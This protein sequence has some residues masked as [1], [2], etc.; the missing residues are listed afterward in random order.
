MPQK[1]MKAKLCGN[2]MDRMPG[3]SFR[4]MAWMFGIA[5]LFSSPHRKLDPFGLKEGMTVVDYGCGTGR[6]LPQASALVGPAGRVYAVDVHE[7]AIEAAHRV[8]AR[9]GLT[10]VVPVQAE[11]AG[12]PVPDH[13]ADVIYALDMFHMVSDPA[14]FL[15]YLARIAKPGG[16]L[17]L[18]DGHQP[19][20]ATRKKVLAS[21][22]WRIEE[23]RPGFVVCRPA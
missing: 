7:L 9:H 18:E 19:R 6:F 8:I 17:F 3:W 5:D 2:D 13:V 10:N 15:R 21:G 11:R 14:A 22:V 20:E 12:A 4:I 16:K 23:E 1:T